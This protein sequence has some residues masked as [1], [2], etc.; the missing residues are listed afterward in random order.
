MRERNYQMAEHAG[1]LIASMIP[2]VFLV[3]GVAWVA[4]FFSLWIKIPIAVAVSFYFF[5]GLPAPLVPFHG[6]VVPPLGNFLFT[7][8]GLGSWAVSLWIIF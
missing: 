6:H 5:M 1:P 4:S 3:W 7:L 8:L 2:W